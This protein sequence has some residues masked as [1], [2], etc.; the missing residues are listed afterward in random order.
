MDGHLLGRLN[1][2][3][4]QLENNHVVATSLEKHLPMSNLTMSYVKGMQ[5]NAVR[6]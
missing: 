3:I 6:I 2:C 1:K 4:S 5:I